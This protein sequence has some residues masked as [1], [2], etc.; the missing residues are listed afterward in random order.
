MLPIPALF[1]GWIILIIVFIEIGYRSGSLVH[2]RTE[3]EKESPVSA[4]SAAILG[5]LAFILAFAFGIATERYDARRALVRE[6]ANIARTAWLRSEFL[7]QA[8]CDK[9]KEMIRDYVQ[10]R[11]D[12][13]NDANLE[14][15]PEA[16]AKTVAVQRQLWDIAKVN[17]KAD[18]NS[19]VGAL[20]IESL[21]DLINVHATRVSIGV[22][23]RM[24]KAI[25][26]V[27]STLIGLG[28][29]G[30]GYQTAI[31]GSKRS[32]EKLILAVSF[33]IVLSLIAILDRPTN[34]YIPVSQ[35]PLM[36]FLEFTAPE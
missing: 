18:M 21:N 20:Y 30:I 27:L 25:W 13:V 6:E 34:P 28:M 4:I 1:V 31:A 36:D 9:A 23:T 19:D 11:I 35:K 2:K 10:T 8:Q 17:A 16:L 26:Y 3:D 7:P 24:P 29:F 33:S 15:L 12:V 22:N 32:W 5:L 14:K